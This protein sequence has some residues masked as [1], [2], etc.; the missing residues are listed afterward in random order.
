MIS[1]DQQLEAHLVKLLWNYDTVLID[2]WDLKQ[3]MLYV[4]DLDYTNRRTTSVTVLGASWTKGRTETGEVIEIY[5]RPCPAYS[6]NIADAWDMLETLR[7]D[8]V[9]SRDHRQL[10][11]MIEYRLERVQMWLKD[12]HEA[13]RAICLI[14]LAVANDAA[15]IAAE[16]LPWKTPQTDTD[17]IPY[18]RGE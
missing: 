13:A 12:Q 7:N 9:F 4:I 6:Y 8:Y 11:P 10:W 16:P 1:R 15:R 17:R 5:G 18:P 14:V 2:S 3:L